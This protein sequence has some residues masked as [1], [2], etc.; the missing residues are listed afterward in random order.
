MARIRLGAFLASCALAAGCA[1]PGPEGEPPRPPAPP[2]A[3]T[4]PPNLHQDLLRQAKDLRYAQRWY[5][6]AQAYRAFLDKEPK[7]PRAPDARFWLAA[8]LESDQRWDEA[9]QA[10]TAFLDQYPDQRVLAKEAKLNRIRCWGVRQGQAPEATPGLL[11]ALRDPSPEV[12]VAAALQLA[13]TGDPRSLEGLRKGLALANSADACSLAMLSMG[14]KPPPVKA[15]QA[16]FLVIRV[17]EPGKDPVTIRLAL[18]LARAVGNFLSD[19]QIR[20]ARA[21]G[22]DLEGFTERAAAAPKGTELLTV[23]DGKSR[24]E[25]V[26][27]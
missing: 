13:K 6:A 4:L 10:Y 15:A 22:V 23:D 1:I 21:K 8:T 7:S 26:V 12:Q 16:K 25:I 2:R 14:V 9:S 5:E 18:S 19:A 17:K 11:A 24:V 20:E 27:D 3:P